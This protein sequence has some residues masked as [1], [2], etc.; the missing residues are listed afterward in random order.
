MQNIAMAVSALLFVIMAFMIV[1]NY[2]LGPMLSQAV[3]EANEKMFHT[4]SKFRHFI[5][6]VDLWL[7]RDYYGGCC[8]QRGFCC[9]NCRE[10]GCLRIHD[11]VK[12]ERRHR[13][14]KF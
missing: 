14:R 11:L 2:V 13:K 12:Q 7:N 5:D 6:K 9:E 3:S 4:P 10:N 8:E 1:W